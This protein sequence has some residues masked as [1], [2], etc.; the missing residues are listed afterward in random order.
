MTIV[1]YIEMCPILVTQTNRWKIEY[2]I[3][4]SLVNVCCHGK[5]TCRYTNQ[6]MFYFQINEFIR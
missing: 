4:I 1:L 6:L 3:C 2:K 5:K